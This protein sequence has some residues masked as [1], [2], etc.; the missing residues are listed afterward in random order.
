[1]LWSMDIYYELVIKICEE[2][3]KK[4]GKEY[5]K[6]RQ[7]IFLLPMDKQICGFVKPYM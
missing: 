1:M 7:K 4:S 6:I 2:I 5:W 3:K